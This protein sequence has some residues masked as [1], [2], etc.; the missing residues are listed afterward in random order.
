[1]VISTDCIDTGVS[2]KRAEQVLESLEKLKGTVAL[3]KTRYNVLEAD[4]SA[5]LD[6]AIRRVS[7]LMTELE[8]VSEPVDA[9]DYMNPGILPGMT[10]DGDIAGNGREGS[11]K[12]PDP[13]GNSEHG[14][15]GETAFFHPVISQSGLSGL[16]SSSLERGRAGESG[17]VS[18]ARRV[19]DLI[20]DALETG[21]DKIGDGIIFPIE[22][23]LQMV[24]PHGK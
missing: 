16:S 18:A 11:G 8:K 24:H 2:K 14:I 20:G 5:V 21:L 12:E 15:E 17:R 1:M 7:Q 23:V 9:P 13:S 22:K 6:D 10:L 19:V 3:V 4:Y